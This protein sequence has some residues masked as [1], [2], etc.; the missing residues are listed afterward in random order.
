AAPGLGDMFLFNV[1][2]GQFDVPTWGRLFV[3]Q[4]ESLVD[5]VL[6]NK[7]AQV[8]T[9]LFEFFKGKEKERGP[10]IKSIDSLMDA[11]EAKSQT[12]PKHSL[13]LKITK[14]ADPIGRLKDLMSTYEVP[15]WTESMYREFLLGEQ[16]ERIR[17]EEEQEAT[18]Q[19]RLCSSERAP[20]EGPER[21]SAPEPDAPSFR[22]HF[23]WDEP[24]WEDSE[25]QGMDLSRPMARGY[26]AVEGAFAAAS[27]RP[28]KKTYKEGHEPLLK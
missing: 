5:G 21:E 9:F 6:E 16:L 22:T 3:Q 7:R 25:L 23:L 1:S 17:K 27:R 15:Y 19:G 26:G 12:R 11:L 2:Q 10:F 24:S 14:D 28:L 8:V 18:L 4:A 13:V 20:V